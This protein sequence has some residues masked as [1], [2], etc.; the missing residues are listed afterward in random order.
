MPSRPSLA[1]ASQTMSQKLYEAASA[2]ASQPGAAGESTSAGGRRD[3]DVIDA[4]IV[5]EK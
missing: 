4:E 5:D 1:T 2:A 3:D